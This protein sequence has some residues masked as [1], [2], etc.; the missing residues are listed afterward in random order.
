MAYHTTVGFSQQ[1]ICAQQIV[2]VVEQ[3]RD[4]ERVARLTENGVHEI[5]LT[6]DRGQPAETPF[7]FADHKLTSD[8]I[9]RAAETV[10]FFVKWIDSLDTDRT[11]EFLTIGPA[12]LI[13]GWDENEEHCG[14]VSIGI[15]RLIPGGAPEWQYELS[16]EKGLVYIS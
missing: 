15:I 8:Q 14:R 2:T 12:R 6:D 10:R 13:L 7:R 11:V 9:A 5:W 1:T 3:L 16:P 4:A